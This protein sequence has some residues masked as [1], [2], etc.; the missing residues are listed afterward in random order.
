[1]ALLDVKEMTQ[2]FGGLCA[3]SEFTV[4]LEQGQMAA[5]I[6][7]NGAGKT[8]VFNLVSGFYK[9]TRGEIIFDGQSIKGLKP[10]QVTSRGIARTFQNIRLWFEM[11][12][13]DN[14]RIAQHHALGYGLFD[15]FLRT[16][17]YM[18][19]ER[20]IED[21]AM[22]VLSRLGLAEV[23]NELPKNLP[24][25]VQRLV[26]IA[27]ALSIK[28]KLLMLDEPAAGLNSADVEGL[29]KLIGDIHRDYGIAI[30]MIEHQMDVVMSL[31]SWIKVI[32][33]GATIA[34]GTPEAIQNNPDVIKAY[35][36]DD[37]I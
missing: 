14:I 20:D 9:P 17:R 24:Y 22:E 31:C 7:P 12:V 13:L 5:L 2:Y 28:P 32:D 4:A 18:R 37:T 23:A 35:L 19:R 33:F 8:T 30:W 15:C 16:P 10:H 11:T 27:R 6:G 36:G 21:H 34:E 3:V 25:G 1:M 26:E 29:I